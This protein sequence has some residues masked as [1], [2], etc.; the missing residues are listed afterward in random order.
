MKKDVFFFVLQN[1]TNRRKWQ[2]KT[3]QKK[4]RKKL[5]NTK[6]TT[7]NPVFLHR[8]L[9]LQAQHKLV[10]LGV[11]ELLGEPDVGHALGGHHQAEVYALEQEGRAVPQAAGH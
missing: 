11:D 6:K 1:N 7:N 9:G 8:G 3:R 10:G 5:Q 2:M 4:K